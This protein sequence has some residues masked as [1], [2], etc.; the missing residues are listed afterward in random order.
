LL[1]FSLQ[2]CPRHTVLP[3]L[4]ER[5]QAAFKLRL[6][7]PRQG[8]LIVVQTVPKLRNQRNPLGDKRTISSGVSNS[9][10]REYATTRGRQWAFRFA[11]RACGGVATPNRS[12]RS[13]PTISIQSKSFSAGA[14]VNQVTGYGWSPLLVA[15][16]NRYYK[17]GAF[18][19]EHGADVNLA[20]NGLW[21]PLYIATDNRNIESGD[22]PVRKGDMA[23]VRCR[24]AVRCCRGETTRR[25]AR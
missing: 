23:W 25:P 10:I 8:K 7:R 20:N 4:V 5:G 3:I 9:I 2:G 11:Y 6:L 19:P 16:Q 15:T 17:L 12:M 13:A 22:Y 1:E 14:D 18:L 21:T 24:Y